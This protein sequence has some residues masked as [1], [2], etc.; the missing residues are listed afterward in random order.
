ML[1]LHC[2]FPSDEGMRTKWAKA[3]NRVDPDNPMKVL[4][5]PGPA[6][7][8]CS[9]HFLASDYLP[10]IS[11]RKLKPTAVP[12]IFSF[13]RP[14]E[15]SD[16]TSRYK[17]KYLQLTAYVPS[18]SASEEKWVERAELFRKKYHNALRREKRLRTTLSNVLS[19]LKELQVINED[20]EKILSSFKGKFLP[21]PPPP[22][23]I[24][25]YFLIQLI[26]II[27]Y[28]HLSFSTVSSLDLFSFL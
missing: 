9:D 28:L 7:F 1:V 13:Q 22:S 16:R 4:W 3:C 27:R 21:P 11:I 6:A 18:S 20:L 2:R 25:L 17:E 12:S 14:H 8:I 26:D 23:P 19:D 24:I 5:Q 15:E 10:N